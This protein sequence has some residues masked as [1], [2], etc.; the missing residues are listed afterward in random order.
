MYDPG[1]KN[2]FKFGLNFAELGI[3]KNQF[4]FRKVPIP[5]RV[6]KPESVHLHGCETKKFNTFR[7]ANRNSRIF[8]K[9]VAKLY[10]KKLVG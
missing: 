4:T 1:P 2:I 10:I 5:W 9:V 3:R 8:C 6:L 7:V